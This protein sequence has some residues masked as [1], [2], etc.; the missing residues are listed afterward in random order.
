[1]P[2]IHK[3]TAS[4]K[5]VE[6]FG[7]A[8]ADKPVVYL[9]TFEGEGSRVYER[10]NRFSFTLVAVGG[11]DWNRDMSP[12]DIP[13]ISK[14]DA[15]CT[16]GAEDYLRILTGEII[17]QAEDCIL[18]K[19]LWRGLAGYSLAGLFALYSLYRTDIFTRIASMSGSLWFPDFKE[20]VF[21]H[22]PVKEPDCIYFSL[23]DKEARTRNPYLKPVRENTEAI[24][25]FYDS[26]GVPTEFVL[27]E[28]NHFNKAAERTAAGIEWILN[29]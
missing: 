22:E 16:G 1:M 3:F 9:N 20:Y 26:R 2:A 19:P 11:L 4:G 5:T 17:P 15:P 18:G 12:W 29:F 27:N 24:G 6:V 21:S 25:K 8:A 23:G 10:L 13:P 14:N 7:C 28:G